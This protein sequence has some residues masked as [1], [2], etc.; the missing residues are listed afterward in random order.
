VTSFVCWVSLLSSERLGVPD[1]R[2]RDRHHD[3]HDEGATAASAP[4]QPICSLPTGRHGNH[5]GVRNDG[6]RAARWIIASLVL[7]DSHR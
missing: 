3:R 2:V 6:S 7:R 5:T 4:E 1:L